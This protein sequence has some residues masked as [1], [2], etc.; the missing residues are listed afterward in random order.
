MTSTAASPVIDQSTL[1]PAQVRALWPDDMR[2]VDA[3][4]RYFAR[5]GFNDSTYTARFIELPALGTTLYLPNI[6]DRRAAVRVHDL[7]H[8]LTGYGTDWLGESLISTFELGMGVRGYWVAWVLDSSAMLMGLTREPR[9][10][11]RAFARGHATTRST[12]AL[13]PDV[14]AP[15]MEHTLQE[16]IGALRAAVGIVDD[17]PF[18]LSAGLA[19]IGHSVAAVLATPLILGVMVPAAIWA[20]ITARRA[21]R[22]PACD[23]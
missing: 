5:S 19:L 8:V 10:M 14:N 4:G 17:A 23:S 16:P 21:K 18:T 11:L 12:Y 6:A 7:N 20:T 9:Q 2:V 1:S 15:D 13:L 3:R 22:S